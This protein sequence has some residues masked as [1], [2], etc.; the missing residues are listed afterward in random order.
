MI[1]NIVFSSQSD[2]IYYIKWALS[3]LNR[4]ALYTNIEN[5]EY[6]FES[7]L[8]FKPYTL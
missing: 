5:S 2:P 8:I 7:S 4:Y 6:F 3:I 1:F